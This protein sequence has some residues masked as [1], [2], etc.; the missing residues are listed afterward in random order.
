M[1]SFLSGATMPS[2]S[3]T[4]SLFILISPFVYIK[5]KQRKTKQKKERRNTSREFLAVHFTLYNIHTVELSLFIN[6]VYKLRGW[7]KGH[8]ENVRTPQLGSWMVTKCQS[9]GLARPLYCRPMC[10]VLPQPMYSIS[11]SRVKILEKGDF[12]DFLSIEY[13]VI[14]TNITYTVYTR[15]IF[16]KVKISSVLSKKTFED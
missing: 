6:E 2:S 12:P 3:S 5:Q 11:P 16:T 14:G 9:I 4:C 10:S 1:S 13:S 15:S 8:S 7:K